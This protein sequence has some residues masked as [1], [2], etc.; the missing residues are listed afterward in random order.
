MNRLPLPDDTIR[1]QL[2]LNDSSDVRA[3]NI[4]VALIT[5][6][7]SNYGQYGTA[8]NKSAANVVI[9]LR[10]L[11]EIAKIL[12]RA[13]DEHQAFYSVFQASLVKTGRDR[14]G[15]KDIRVQITGWK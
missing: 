5:T 3:S 4:F 9:H 14:L 13:I 12:R 11:D 10:N 15:F 1:L 7:L 8:L 2:S 6:R